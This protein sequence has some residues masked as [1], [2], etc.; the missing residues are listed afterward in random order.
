M[1]K[2]DPVERALT[3][4]QALIRS[5]PTGG[6]EVVMTGAVPED[7]Q[8]EDFKAIGLPLEESTAL[9]DARS[10]LSAD[11]RFEYLKDHDVDRITW[12]FVCR[13][14]L[15]RR[16]DLVSDFVEEHAR[17][18][19]DRTCFFPI[20]LL[21]IKEE[22]ALY[23]VR[24]MPPDAVER[25]PALFGHDPGPTIGSIIAIECTGTDYGKMSLRARAVAE[26][27]LRLLRATFREERWMPDRQLRFR[28][29]AVVWFDDS[30]RAGWTSP[31][32]EGWELELDDALLRH[33]T[34]QQ[35]STL[36]AEA[37]NDV[38]S[39]VERALEWFERGQLAVEPIVKL[40]YLFS[41]LEAILGDKSEKLKAPALAV[42][43]AMLGLLTSGGFT[44]PNRTYLLYDEVRSYAIHG[45]APRAISQR[46]VDA[47]AW[48][49]HAQRASLG[50]P[51]CEKR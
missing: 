26:R 25:P 1:G 37:S 7:L 40:L 22:A 14:H 12:R 13:A 3:K 18:P 9:E 32:E 31:P 33:A 15:Q 19:M 11:L 16:G 6:E 28:L 35:I 20:E 42:R 34:S 44:H 29:G 30:I 27:A 17:E 38:E 46:E 2:R 43:R 36:P 5:P 48:N 50:A 39:R 24:L 45:E 23:G 8:S 41:A 49:T 51:T 4:L 21:T 47:F 10:L